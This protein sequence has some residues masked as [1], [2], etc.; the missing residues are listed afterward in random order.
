MICIL[1]HEDVLS[2]LVSNTL[3]PQCQGVALPGKNGYMQDT[4]YTMLS[5]VPCSIFFLPVLCSLHLS[6]T[7]VGRSDCP[8]IVFLNY[9]PGMMYDVTFS[10]GEFV[11]D[12]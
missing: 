6:L 9:I 1:A 8:N 12:R 7:W 3:R 11:L 5:S 2:E 4:W 10:T